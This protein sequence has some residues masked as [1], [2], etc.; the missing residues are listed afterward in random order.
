MNKLD[1]LSMS[2]K[3]LWRRKTR[4]I[5]TILGVVIGTAAIII[6]LALGIAMDQGFKDQLQQ[7]GSLILL[8]FSH[9]TM[10]RSRIT[11]TISLYCLMQLL[12]NVLRSYP[13]WRQSCRKNL[14]LCVLYRA[15]W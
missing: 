8:R 3:S 9:N 10:S 1:L 2:L 6:M 4:T 15:K 14:F 5:L 13:G 7:M 12:L 11:G